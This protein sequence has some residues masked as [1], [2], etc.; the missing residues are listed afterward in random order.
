MD[1]L[2][3]PVPEQQEP[4]DT[5]SIGSWASTPVSMHVNCGLPDRSMSLVS[6]V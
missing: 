3:E 1:S 2:Y 4:K 6:K 5:T